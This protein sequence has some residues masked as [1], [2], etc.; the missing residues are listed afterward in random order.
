MAEIVAA[1]LASHAPGITNRPEIAGREG[2]RPRLRADPGVDHRLR[3]GLAR[4]VA[5]CSTRPICFA[6]AVAHLD[7]VDQP[8][9]F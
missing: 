3:H 6:D 9:E 7:L 8:A 2:R 1:V 4:R 5:G